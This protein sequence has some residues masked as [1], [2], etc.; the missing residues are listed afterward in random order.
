M[1]N[2]HEKSKLCDKGENFANKSEKWHNTVKILR[3][4]WNYDI[5]SYNSKRKSNSEIERPINEIKP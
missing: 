3:N 1:K 4:G 2:G 5:K